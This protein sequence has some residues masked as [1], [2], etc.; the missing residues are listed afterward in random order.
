M[1]FQVGYDQIRSLVQIYNKL[2]SNRDAVPP[3]VTGWIV[4]PVGIDD[5]PILDVTL[6][7]KTDSD[8]A[9]RRIADEILHRMQQVPDTGR[10]SVVGGRPRQIR[11]LL[12]ANRLAVGGDSAGGALAAIVAQQ[13]KAKG[14]PKIAYQMLFFPVTQIGEETVSLNEF[15]EG[16]LLDRATLFWFYEHYLP[17]DADR[18]DSRVSPLKAADLSGL[19]PAYVMLAGFDPLHDEGLAYAERLRAAGV[20]VQIADYPDMVH[21]FILLQAAVPQAQRAIAFTQRDDGL[22]RSLAEGARAHEERTVVILQRAGDDLRGRGRAAVDQHHQRQLAGDVARLGVEAL[23]VVRPPRLG[24]DDLALVEEIVRHLDGLVEKPTRIVAQV[25]DDALEPGADLFPDLLH[26]V[27]DA[28]RRLLAER[29]DADVA[30]LAFGLPAHRL[31][32]DHRAGQR[33]VE[34]IAPGAADGQHDVGVDGAAHPLDRLVQ[35]HALHRLVVERDDEVA[36]L[37]AGAEGRRVVDRRTPLDEAVLHRA[38]DAEPAEL[39]AGLHL[40]VAEAFRIHVARMRIK[41]GQHAVDRRF[42]Q[43]AVVRFFD[44]VGAYALE[45]V[46]EQV[47]LAVGVRGVV[48]LLRRSGERRYQQ[49]DGGRSRGIPRRPSIDSSIAVSSPQM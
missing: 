39:A 26:R 32:L 17:S 37:D 18:A 28:V 30:D 21:D 29:G 38:L 22:H 19:P 34:R 47:E 14:G 10:S 2:E 36:R 48:L 35:G 27:L 44:I 46:A 24:R 45:Y 11:V 3:G 9:L 7:S 4:K 31:D 49:E 23:G 15:A 43:L 40:H 33:H 5:V 42:D 16:Y 25:E 1:R 20:E 12:D 13:A 6:W 41:T 8:A